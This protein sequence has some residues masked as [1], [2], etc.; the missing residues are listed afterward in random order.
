MKHQKVHQELKEIRPELKELEVPIDP[1][2]HRRSSLVFGRAY[3]AAWLI[4][5]TWGSLAFAQDRPALDQRV[6]EL[7]EQKQSE[8]ERSIFFGAQIM[9]NSGHADRGFV[10]ND[11]PVVQPVVWLSGSVAEVSLWGSFPLTR[12]TS[13][14][15]PRILELEVAVWHQWENLRMAP[16]VMMYDYLDPKSIYRTRSIEGWLY[17]SYDAGPFSV[18]SNQSVDV[19]TYGGAYY[20][21]AGIES[22]WR[23]LPAIEVGGSVGAGWASS[24]FNDMYVDV[25]ESAFNRVSVQSW[26]TVYVA[27]RSYIRTHVEFSTI[28]DHGVR[29]EATRPTFVFAGLT[30]GVEF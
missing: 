28:I 5:L 23:V 6:P 14:P 8:N 3:G 16:A 1:T 21:E 11:R 19:L 7:P 4:C 10:I 13:G 15:E 2:R 29:A 30:T 18:F 9:V 25:Y 22:E 12:T 17:L 24:K 27:P 20:G 26:L